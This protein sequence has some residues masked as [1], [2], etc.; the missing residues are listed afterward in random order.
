MSTSLFSNT[1]SV[2]VSDN[3][4]LPVRELQY[5]R[6]PDTPAVTEERITRHQ[7]DARGFLTQSADPRLHAAGLANFTYRNDLTGVVIRTDS[8][9][10]G[11]SLILGDADVRPFLTV[12]NA[13]TGEA[14]IRIWGYEDA[15]LPGRPLSVTEQVAGDAARVA[16]R[17]VWAGNSAEEKALN[18]AGQRVSHYDTAGLV[19]TDSV[20]LTGVQLSVTRRLLQDADSPDTVA[21]WQGQDASVWNDLLGTETHI[22]LTTTDAT[23]AV[24]TTTDAKGNLQRVAY[25]VAG[26]LSGS[27][28]TVKG[29]KEQVIV[30]SLTWSA[31]GQKLREVHGNGV[32]TTYTYEPETQ[33]LTG[34]RTERPAGHAAGA[35][36]LQDLRYAYD[37]VGNVLKISNDAEETRFWRNQKVVP[38]NTYVYDSL[39]QMVS[40]TGREMADAGQQGSGLPGVPSFGEATYTNYTRTYTHDSAGNLTQMRH[41]APATDN[42]HTTRITI[43]SRSNRGVLSTLAENASEVDALFTAGG[44]QKQLQPG[45]G[46]VWTARNELRKVTPVVRDGSADD[47]EYYRYDADSQRL[48]KVSVQKTGSSTQA[49]RVMYL[50]GIELRTT[51]GGGTET[52]SLQV[53][54]VVGA[55]RAQVRVLHWESGRP[56]DIT[57]NQTRYSYDNLT[58][59]S[60]LEVDGEGNVISMEEYYPYGGTAVWAARSQTEADYKTV[61]YSGKERDATGLYYYGYRYYQPWAGRW[62]SADPAGTVDGL[63]LFRMVRNNPASGYDIT[64]FMWKAVT[65]VAIGGA[66]LGYEQYKHSQARK[67]EPSQ[68][69]SSTFGND[70]IHALNKK[71]AEKQNDFS[72]IDKV[73][74]NLSGR[75]KVITDFLTKGELPANDSIMNQK[76]NLSTL[77][78]FSQTGSIEDLNK[79]K[80]AKEFASDVSSNIPTRIYQAVKG[81]RVATSVTPEGVKELKEAADTMKENVKDTIAVGVSV[82]VI[83]NAALTLA[84][85]AIPGAAIPLTAAQVAWAAS[86]AG[87]VVNQVNEEVKTH[88]EKSPISHEARTEALKQMREANQLK[89]GVLLDKARSFIN[90]NE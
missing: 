22:T 1:P 42:S 61:R 11:T 25:D 73:K 69:S 39:Y 17:F 79:T 10:A 27:W 66:T 35:K 53:M 75:G 12:T 6:H 63:N 59:S 86:S 58:G 89:R 21:D 8:A 3:R 71:A 78:E 70:K 5:Y 23:G 9:D 18:L 56:A 43:S 77:V 60:Q 74:N 14:V 82:G 88:I 46:L 51:S 7:Y 54:T 38:E 2:I 52:E 20:A 57:N 62:L 47:G 49:Q 44:Q 32:V 76:E 55:G 37:P 65:S 67:T 15:T 84:K 90:Q 40:A 64:G 48:L 80:L 34:I 31:A 30:K 29:G 26:L 36:V 72:V 50:P 87:K 85:V 4:G 81:L 83:G 68:T 45:Q 24:L 13:G 41:S 19:Q 33:W 16:E 28:L